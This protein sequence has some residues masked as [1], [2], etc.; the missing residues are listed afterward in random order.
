MNIEAIALEY[1]RL[2]L[3][4]IPVKGK[5][6]GKD[7]DDAKHPFF[8]WKKY[9]TCR[10]SPPEISDW[11]RRWPKAGLAAVT[12]PISGTIVLDLD[13]YKPDHECKQLRAGRD[14]PKTW[15]VQTASGG[16]HHYFKWS[17]KLDTLAKTSVNGI[18]K[19]VDFKGFGGYV[20]LPPTTGFSGNVYK[21][22]DGCSYA[23]C[24]LAEIPDWLISPLRESMPQATPKAAGWIT[25]ELA[26]AGDNRRHTPFVSVIGRLHRGRVSPEDIYGLLEPHAERTGYDLKELRY[27]INHLTSRYPQSNSFLVSDPYKDEKQETIEMKAITLGEF[28]ATGEP[29]ITWRVEGILPSEGVAIFGGPSGYGKSWALLD[30]A[31]ECARGGKWMGHFA[32]TQ[33]A[34]L[35]VD[36]ESSP[37]L[38][39]KR[40]N[41]L[42]TAKGIQPTGLNGIRLMV[43]SGLCLTREKSVEAFRRDLSQERPALII[44]DALIR[45]F[46]GDENSASD[47]AQVF[48]PIKEIVRDFQCAVLFADHQKKFSAIAGLSGDQMLRGSSEKT[49]FV[50]TLLSLSKRDDMLFVEHSKSRFAEPVPSFAIRIHDNQEKTET[51]VEYIGEAEPLKQAARLQPVFEFLEQQFATDSPGYYRQDLV[52]AAKDAGIHGKLLDEAL[53]AWV[54]DGHLIRDDRREG[55]GKARAYYRK[56]SSAGTDS[57]LFLVSTHIP[58]KQ[59]TIPSDVPKADRTGSDPGVSK[60][61]EMFGGRVRT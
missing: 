48:A 26:N 57:E 38:I 16:L 54:A 6:Y 42:L 4:L 61:L 27:Q 23:S 43:G 14:V 32:T 41:K 29:D 51:R 1:L 28:M 34:V 44:I 30:L 49:A 33:G 19:G 50:D 53:K 25:A 35:Y 58:E 46:R 22:Q 45:V 31:I 40:V 13:L 17:D 9:Q 60:V 2:G 20:I 15:T 5:H 36:E 56:K 37:Q 12:G 11:F 52:A 3:S 24:D 21:W 10:A 39:R 47:M 8:E 59:E 55:Q 18:Y 7:N